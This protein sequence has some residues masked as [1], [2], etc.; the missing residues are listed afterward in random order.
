MYVLGLRFIT[1]RFQ[2]L[3]A[4]RRAV[5]WHGHYF[6][7]RHE[8]R[9]LHPQRVEPNVVLSGG[10]AVFPELVERMTATVRLDCDY[11][12]MRQSTEA[13]GFIGE[14]D[15]TCYLISGSLQS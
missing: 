6:Q 10:T 11:T 14:T 8:L 15:K 13:D 4:E 5:R 9:R 3:Y 1:A 12:L 2:E 7:E